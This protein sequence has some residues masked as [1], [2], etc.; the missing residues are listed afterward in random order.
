MY[1]ALLRFQTKSYFQS[2]LVQSYSICI[3]IIASNM[4]SYPGTSRMKRL[5]DY[6]FSAKVNSLCCRHKRVIRRENLLWANNQTNN[7]HYFLFIFLESI[8]IQLSN[9]SFYA[10]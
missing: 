7:P 6:E 1:Y 4:S 3:L 9:F 8:I 2:D 5:I 10:K